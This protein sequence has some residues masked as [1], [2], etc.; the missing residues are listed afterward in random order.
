MKI[1]NKSAA[2]AAIGF[3]A[4][5]AAATAAA[6]CWKYANEMSVAATMLRSCAAAQ[7]PQMLEARTLWAGPL[8]C[9]HGIL[10]GDG[11]A[12]NADSLWQAK[13]ENRKRPEHSFYGFSQNKTKNQKN[14]KR[15]QS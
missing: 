3:D 11:S 1:N 4:D 8:N 14:Q 10:I 12:G 6:V 13:R 9:T 15:K 2:V 7:M 5:A